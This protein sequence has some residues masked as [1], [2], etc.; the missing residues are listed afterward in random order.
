MAYKLPVLASNMNGIG[1]LTFKDATTKGV[2]RATM[3]QMLESIVENTSWCR[4]GVQLRRFLT[5]CLGKAR[6]DGRRMNRV[7]PLRRPLCPHIPRKGPRLAAPAIARPVWTGQRSI[8]VSIPRIQIRRM[9]RD[10]NHQTSVYCLINSRHFRPCP[11]L[12]GR[13]KETGGSCQSP[14]LVVE[15][16][17]SERSKCDVLTPAKR[18]T[19]ELLTLD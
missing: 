2:L 3:K 19:G 16:A 10:P 12:P 9:R 14:R 7:Q 18:L 5:R 15:P 4:V 17:R 13:R 11:N 8:L 6:M 1:L